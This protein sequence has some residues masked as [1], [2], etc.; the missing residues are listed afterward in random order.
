MEELTSSSSSSILLSSSNSTHSNN[1]ITN[2]I[3]TSCSPSNPKTD[4]HLTS[5][6][7]SFPP[8]AKNQL[9]DAFDNKNYSIEEYEKRFINS[10]KNLNAPKWLVSNNNNKKDIL[11]MIN[12]DSANKFRLSAPKQE[13][14]FT[15]N[16]SASKPSFSAQAYINSTKNRY[17][18]IRLKSKQQSFNGPVSYETNQGASDEISRYSHNGNIFNNNKAGLKPNKEDLFES[19]QYSNNLNAKNSK[20]LILLATTSTSTTNIIKSPIVSSINNIERIEDSIDD[21][22]NKSQPNINDN[23]EEMSFKAPHLCPSVYVSDIKRSLSNYT[24]FN[25]SSTNNLEP[26]SQ[27]NYSLYYYNS[28]LK[29][30]KSTNF[31]SNSW[32]K[33]QML[34]LPDSATD[35]NNESSRN[36]PHAFNKRKAETNF[37]EFI[38]K[39]D[40]NGRVLY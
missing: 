10:L 4:S 27:S 34:R 5:F 7:V 17:Y 28:N 20:S 39:C 8:N 37:G 35:V 21:S 18:K 38:L 25:S 29:Y 2:L 26:L 24:C 13:Q 3:T 40:L 1:S 14:P 11:N 36:E 33:P 23:R 9:L 15:S 6:K 22:T 32:Y 19:R 31:N 12:Q 30:S 16:G